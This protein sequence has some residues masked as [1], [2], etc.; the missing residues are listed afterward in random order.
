MEIQLISHHILWY[1]LLTIIAIAIGFISYRRS[2]PPLGKVQRIF[3]FTLRAAMLLLLGIFLIEPLIN[4]YS[5]KTIKPQ[6]AVLM[7]ISKSMGVRDGTVSRMVEAGE[8]TQKALGNIK[9]EHRI[10]D[11]SSNIK[12]AD[13]IPGESDLSGDATSIANALRD[14]ASR[15]DID[16][17][18]A[19]VIA[20]DGRQN[21]GEDPVSTAG[22]L[23]MPVYTLT[24]GQ[25]KPEINLSIDNLIYPTVAY[26][27]AD[28]KIEA[29]LSAS[30][31]SASKS[32]LFLKLGSNVV[33]DKPFDIPRESRKIKVSFEIKAPEPGNYEYSLS[34]PILEGETNKVDNDRIF[35][36]RILKNKLK[37]FLGSSNL[38]W[39]FKF[40][41]QALS[42]F[43][44]FD[45]DA[46]YSQ[47][48][49][50]FAFPG[51]PRGLDG[52]KKYDTIILIN[53]APGELHISTV[54]LEKYINDGG[55]L[56]YLGGTNVINN[57]KM[58]ADLLPIKLT[59]PQI[60]ESEYFFEPAPTRKQHAAILMDDDPDQ[61]AQLWHSLP[62]F[63]NILS[64]IEPT[65][66]V[67]L[68]AGISINDS[69]LNARIPS[70]SKLDG[71]PV[72]TV[73][74]HG[75]G[76]VAAITGYP[77][78]QS[79]FGSVRDQKMA[80]A[81]PS[82]WRNLVKWSAATDQMQ[83]FKV[84]TGR[85]VHRLG[86]PVR[87]TG[88]L[89]DEANRP[90][91]GAYV[92]VSLMPDSQETSVKDI[93]LPPVDNGIY[94]EEIS[95][96]APGHYNFKAYATGYGDTLGKASG[97]FT[98]ENFSLEMASSAPDYN[99]T[100][101]IS[102]AT[103]GVA[104]TANDFQKFP[105]QLKLIPYVKENQASIRPFGLPLLLGILL[106]GFCLEWALRKRFRL[107]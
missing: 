53:S 99:L 75:K 38:N 65:G 18:A 81:I 67:L 71:Q 44:E 89:Y 35:A 15:K 76:R 107:P 9:A 95:S 41:K 40:V 37:L 24:V 34:A 59:N 105:E 73:A 30:G 2:F 43:E 46:V 29:E 85:K 45:I 16:N 80:G 96:L 86:E 48:P 14:L 19:V 79:Y 25:Q 60:R 31:I 55:S 26:S 88:Y 36:I 11:F 91:S 52:F 21:L 90:K 93:I 70:P 101:R 83:N 94:S 1:I 20:T 57:I 106:A 64:G 13:G 87:L 8:L 6:I 98:I 47:A 61:S 5:T 22:K 84:I 62:P 39:E 69:V 23:N 58:F 77:W 66:D 49:G 82:F 63:R 10:F 42:K 27:G 7:D 56:I 28:I 103:G 33:S 100:R 68:E 74:Q 32:R 12:E 104:Y 102:E 51:I 92:A 78:W 3:L 54:D 4:F 17:Y 72:L 97:E 50:N